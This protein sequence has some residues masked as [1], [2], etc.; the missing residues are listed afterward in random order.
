MS[1]LAAAAA[2]AAAVAAAAVSA[3]AAVQCDLER[4]MPVSSGW[5][6]SGGFSRSPGQS[7]AESI[8]G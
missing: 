7:V 8:T 6:Y 3:V 5:P 4:S 1:V 2:A